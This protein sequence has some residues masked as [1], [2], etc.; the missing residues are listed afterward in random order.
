MRLS[1]HLRS[2]LLLFGTWLPPPT[3]L[4]GPANMPNASRSTTVPDDVLTDELLEDI[5]TRCTF[6]AH[7]LPHHLLQ[8]DP[9]LDAM[10]VDESTAPSEIPPSEPDSYSQSVPPSSS[11]VPSSSDFAEVSVAPGEGSGGKKSRLQTIANLY[12]RHSTATDIVMRAVPPASQ[13]HNT[14]RGTL[15]IPGW[16]RERAAEVL[17]EGRDVDESSI[18]EVILDSL[19]KVKELIAH[20]RL[21]RLMRFADS[22]RPA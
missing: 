11:P 22:C 9:S 2:L 20:P 19:L 12:M 5:K 6:V 18:A 21:R 17:F 16:V 14:G 1:S 7:P 10:S 4:G 13:N 3:T 8:E 15:L